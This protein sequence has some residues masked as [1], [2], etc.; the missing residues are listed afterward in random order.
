MIVGYHLIWGAYGFWLPNDPRG[1]WSTYVGSLDLYRA[2]GEATKTDARHSVAY[3]PHD[4]AQR[5]A[6][7]QA[8]QRPAVRFTGL[9]ARA[10]GR[11]FAEYA[12][13]ST[14]PVWACA[15][16]PD[17]VHIVIGRP[18]I[19]AERV[20]QQLKAAAT[21]RLR[22]E[23]L[24]PFQDEPSRKCWA[25]GEWIVY[26]DP[27]DVSRAINYVERNPIREGLPR[28]TWPFVASMDAVY[29]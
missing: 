3:A 13:K 28:Q 24:H 21:H 16:M 1:S 29:S 14:L 20:V 10:V 26:L 19:P 6:V 2:G 17:H 12:R 9:Q 27:N 15:I 7:K 22:T 5:L 8:L 25:Q 23:N 18:H 4:R 11:G